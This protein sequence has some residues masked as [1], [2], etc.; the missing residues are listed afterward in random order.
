MDSIIHVLDE[1][2]EDRVGRL[3]RWLATWS[4]VDVSHVERMINDTHMNSTDC[5]TILTSIPILDATQDDA[6]NRING[7]IDRVEHLV[8]LC[9][10]KAA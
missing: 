10:H 2:I 9:S 1:L 5:E 8:T 4:R 3:Q 7:C 6:M